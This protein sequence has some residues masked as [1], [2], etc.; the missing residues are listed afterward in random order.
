MDGKDHSLNAM[1]KGSIVV[2]PYINL[3]LGNSFLRFVY[4]TKSVFP[5]ALIMNDSLLQ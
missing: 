2:V 5:S 1:N 3:M 4:L